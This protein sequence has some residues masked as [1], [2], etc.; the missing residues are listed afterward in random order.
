MNQSN[1]ASKVHHVVMWHL[2]EEALGRSLRDNAL[3]LKARLE[4]LSAVPGIEYL[5][6]GVD[7]RRRA[8]SADVVM[9]SRFRDQEALE[10]Y[11]DHPLH[12]A[13]KE[14]IDEI[15]QSSTVV[16]FPEEPCLPAE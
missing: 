4:E 5:H 15:R 10:A 8:N 11:H 16:D 14:Y 12:L 3:S 13:V 2:K 6:V 9:I 7:A 1:A